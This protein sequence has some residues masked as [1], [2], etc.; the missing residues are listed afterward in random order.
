MVRNMRSWQHSGVAIFLGAAL[1]FPQMLFAAM[2]STNY[3]IIWD[4]VGVGGENT[5]SSTSYKLRDTVGGIA[6]SSSSS[7]Y[8]ERS[9]FRAGI[10]DPVVDFSLFLE[11]YSTQVA[12]TS[13]SGTS[14]VVSN[15]S[16]F[17]AGDKILVVQ[18]EG[19]NQ[20]TAIGE[21][22]TVVST[23]VTVDAWT[24]TGGTP[25][26]D[27][28]S[29]YVYELSGSSIAFG[30]LSVATV[31]TRVIAWEADADATGGYKVYVK[32]DGDFTTGTFTIPDVGDG[33]V[34][35]GSSEYG[36]RSSDASLTSS[37]FDTQDTGITTTLQEVGSR[38]DNAIESRDFLTLRVAMDGSQDYGSYGQTLTVVFVGNY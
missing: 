14:V 7:S 36:A 5:A 23:T 29:D 4:N 12:A 6:G 35:A 37:T 25:S 21:V 8:Q 18:N 33:T 19:E 10:Y 15:A 11:N 30:T 3:Q 22:V 16:G 32:E 38:A 1:L 13:F 20:V 26:I 24:T 28:T 2:T 34:S 31:A 9:G 27:G 17:A